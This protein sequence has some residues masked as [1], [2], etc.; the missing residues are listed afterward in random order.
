MI[1]QKNIVRKLDKARVKYYNFVEKFGNVLRS[2]EFDNWGEVLRGDHLDRYNAIKSRETALFNVM[3]KIDGGGTTPGS[4]GQIGVLIER[5]TNAKSKAARNAA[6]K[7]I[8]FL[9]AKK[10]TVVTRWEKLNTK[11][12]RLKQSHDSKVNKLELKVDQ[13]WDWL[14]ENGMAPSPPSGTPAPPPS[15]TPVG[16]D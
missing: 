8:D 3:N 11:A 13:Y 12:S 5:E 16:I 14:M 1:T 10:E 6:G 9:R 2:T 4:G 7:K 15:G